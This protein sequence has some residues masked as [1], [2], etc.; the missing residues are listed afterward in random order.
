MKLDSV[1]ELV[2]EWIREIKNQVEVDEDELKKRWSIAWDDVNGGVLDMSDVNKARKEEVGYMQQ[3]R[4][5]PDGMKGIWSLKPISECRNKTGADPV[6]VRWV[7]TNKGTVNDPFVRCRLV[8]RDFKGNDKDRDDLFAETPPLEA[9][10]M[11]ISRAATRRIDGKKRKG[12]CKKDA[13]R[14]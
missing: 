10:R 1:V 6:S 14:M 7:D 9:K 4:K 12:R 13:T 8:A 11:L 2:E 5:H 3:N